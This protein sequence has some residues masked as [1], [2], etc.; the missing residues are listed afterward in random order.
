MVSTSMRVFNTNACGFQCYWHTVTSVKWLSMTKTVVCTLFSLNP[1]ILAL[2]ALQVSVKRKNMLHA[3][4]KKKKKKK[5]LANNRI[6]ML[7]C[8]FQG[9]KWSC[10]LLSLWLMVLMVSRQIYSYCSSGL[11]VWGQP[12][13]NINIV[14]YVQFAQRSGAITPHGIV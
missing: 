11:H 1:Y 4:R 5:L 14:N 7:F 6:Q 13:K 10:E 9:L 2:P 8:T 3:W 12:R